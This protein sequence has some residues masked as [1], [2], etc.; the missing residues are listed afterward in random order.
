MQLDSAFRFVLPAFK[1]RSFAILRVARIQERVVIANS[2][3]NSL[4]VV[5]TN[6]QRDPLRANTPFIADRINQIWKLRLIGAMQRK[7][8]I[9]D[10]STYGTFD[11]CKNNRIFR[12]RFLRRK[13]LDHCYPFE[14]KRTW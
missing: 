9:R 12:T 11:T 10:E 2:H 1:A 3:D 8:F 4:V 5:S 13:V 14:G 7:N 6:R